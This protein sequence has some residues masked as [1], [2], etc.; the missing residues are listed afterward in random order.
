VLIDLF[1]NIVPGVLTRDLGGYFLY[2]EGG[3]A[4]LAMAIVFL[5]FLGLTAFVLVLWVLMPFSVFGIKGLLRQC[6][7]EQ[8]KTNRLLEKILDKGAAAPPVRTAP[9]PV[10]QE[11]VLREETLPEILPLDDD[12][13]DF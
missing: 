10:P 9:P 6:I 12:N 1:S 13:V 8:K 2:S 3:G 7:E 5:I 4:G 11:P